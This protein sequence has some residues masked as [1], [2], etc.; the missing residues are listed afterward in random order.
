[1]SDSRADQWPRLRFESIDST[2]DE[3]KRLLEA[4]ALPC[5]FLISADQQT[6]GRGRGTNAW[7]SSTGSLMFTLAFDPKAFGLEPRHEPLLALLAGLAVVESLPEIPAGIRWPNDVECLGKKLAGVLPERVETSLGVRI[8]MGV[9]VNVTTQFDQAPVEISKMATSVVDLGG[10]LTCEQMLDSFLIHF[11]RLIQELASD[12]PGLTD[13]WNALDTL[14]GTTVRVR[15]N[16]RLIV[17]IGSGI[18]A[19]GGLVLMTESGPTTVYGGTVL[20]D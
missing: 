1:M 3:A 20:R 13:R 19:L 14:L 18:D 16:D 12:D 11:D 9:G 7:W 5:P 17:G 15:Q 2:S 10:F 4:D 8:L 6:K